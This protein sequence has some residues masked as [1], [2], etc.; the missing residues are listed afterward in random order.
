MSYLDLQPPSVVQST[1]SLMAVPEERGRDE[2]AQV[3][4]L[5]AAPPLDVQQLGEGQVQ[6]DLCSGH[7]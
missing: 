7:V 6:G 1:R 5:K 4:I 3:P 2:T